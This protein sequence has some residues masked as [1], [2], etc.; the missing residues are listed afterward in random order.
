MPSQT[1]LDMGGTSREWARVYRGPS[2]GYIWVPQRNVLSITAAGT[3]VLDPSTSLVEVNV[4]GA[5]TITLPSAVVPPVGP[6]AQPGLFAQNPIII[7]DIGGNAQANPI[8]I[9]RNNSNENIMGLASIQIT[10]NYGGYTL[11]PSSVQKGWI[12]ISP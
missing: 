5:V 12:S 3:Y 6:Q 2:V 9:Q 10:T 7:V 11:T 4:A 1:D 8:T